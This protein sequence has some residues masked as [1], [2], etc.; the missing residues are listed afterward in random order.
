MANKFARLN[1]DFYGPIWSL[2][3][4]GVAGSTPNP[5]VG[6]SA[7]TN[8]FLVDITS[9]IA[10]DLLSNTSGGGATAGGRFNA[11]SSTNNINI[12]AN[13]NSSLFGTFTTFTAFAC[14]SVVNPQ[15]TNIYG[16]LF[17]NGTIHG[18]HVVM[19]NTPG[20]VNIYGNIQHTTAGGNQGGVALYVRRV[21]FLNIYGN[22]V[23]G[24]NN[25]AEIPESHSG[26]YI[27]DAKEVRVYGNVSGWG[28][29]PGI[30]TVGGR[31]AV[32]RIYGNV[33][34]ITNNLS[35][36]TTALT[37]N[38]T[39]LVVVY[40][41]VSG[42]SRQ[43]ILNSSSG[44]IEV[45]G[46]VYGGEARAGAHGISN[47]STGTVTVVGDVISHPIGSNGIASI[48]TGSTVKIS[49]NLIGAANGVPAV[50]AP[51]FIFTPIISNG[52]IRYAKDNTGISDDSYQYQFTPD[53]FTT[54]SSPPVSSVRTGILYSGISIG[55][56]SMPQPSAVAYGT[57]YDSNNSKFGLA[58]NRDNVIFNTLL[59]NLSVINSVGDR[60]KKSST[61]EATGHLIASFSN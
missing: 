34:A 52:F 54:F 42:Y 14:L 16:S 6:D 36:T 41:N 30:Y 39:G 33:A 61:T 51:S 1:G 2:T 5:T 46:S 17:A 55:T 48:S 45:Y 58:I 38:G 3:T 18:N 20:S 8:S 12:S 15:I 26:M 37:N 43:G 56:C 7:Y 32:L 11:F 9:D 19:L 40:G 22:V 4:G 35:Y 28:N 49:G 59:N 47:T 10:C 23:G 27:D 24:Q 29:H 57:V 13:I 60:V 50:Y 44:S 25:S 53:S 31:T 21:N